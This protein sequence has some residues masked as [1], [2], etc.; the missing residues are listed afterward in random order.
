MLYHSPFLIR[1]QEINAGLWEEF[2]GITLPKF[3]HSRDKNHQN[4][5]K[6]QHFCSFYDSEKFAF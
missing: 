1:E 3:L 4:K 5:T 6:Q 2:S